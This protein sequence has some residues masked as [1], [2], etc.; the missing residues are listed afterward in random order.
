MFNHLVLIPFATIVQGHMKSYIVGL[1]C[2]VLSL[3][4]NMMACALDI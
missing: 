3:H 1:F 2:V 4:N